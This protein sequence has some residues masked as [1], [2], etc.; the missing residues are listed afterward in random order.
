MVTSMPGQRNWS[1]DQVEVKQVDAQ[2]FGQ[3]GAVQVV[4]IHLQQVQ[5]ALSLIYGRVRIEII[6][7]VNHLT[8]TD[9]RFSS[10]E[11]FLVPAL[12]SGTELSGP[13]YFP[14]RLFINVCQWSCSRTNSRKTD[15]IKVFSSRGA[16]SI[17]GDFQVQEGTC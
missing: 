11:D 16:S 2:M 1:D 4:S 13:F 6:L 8:V 15:Q 14:F 10:L 5:S 9:F 3:G 12:S 17:R 7:G